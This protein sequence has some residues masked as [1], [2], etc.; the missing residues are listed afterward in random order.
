MRREGEKQDEF[1][2][3]GVGAREQRPRTP[4]SGGGFCEEFRFGPRQ[5]GI[6]GSSERDERTQKSPPCGGLNH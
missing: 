6:K 4:P 5:L 1:A 2:A 3:R